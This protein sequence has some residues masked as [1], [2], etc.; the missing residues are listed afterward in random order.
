MSSY[1]IEDIAD[2][3]GLSFIPV[4]LAARFIA[5]EQFH[6]GVFTLNGFD[7]EDECLF[8]DEKLQS[9]LLPHISK[10][11]NAILSSIERGDI[12]VVSST[13]ELS[14]GL[15]DLS[16][17]SMS[18]DELFK[19]IDIFGMSDCVENEGYPIDDYLDKL[20]DMHN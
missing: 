1:S 18:T 6:Y 8:E 3:F 12:S 20:A 2:N 10:I 5:Y 9:A 7:A 17:A 13:R 11:N 15:F 14:T 19:F 4:D 16:S